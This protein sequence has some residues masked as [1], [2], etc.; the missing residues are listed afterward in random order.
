MS[1]YEIDVKAEVKLGAVATSAAGERRPGLAPPCQPSSK[2]KNICPLRL[3]WSLLAFVRLSLHLY[4]PRHN[5]SAG[6]TLKVKD[7]TSSI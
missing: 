1:E 6:K 4:A 2:R 5:S 7:P 3:T